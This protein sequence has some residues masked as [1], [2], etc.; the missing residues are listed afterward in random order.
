[1]NA[2]LYI[3]SRNL[4]YSP[5]RSSPSPIS[6]CLS[7]Y[8]S[9][10]GSGGLFGPP[11]ISD[12]C[13][14]I[15]WGISTALR[16]AVPILSLISSRSASHLYSSFNVSLHAL[17]IGTIIVLYHTTKMNRQVMEQASSHGPAISLINVVYHTYRANSRHLETGIYTKI[18]FKVKKIA[19]GITLFRHGPA[20]IS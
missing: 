2:R 1:M 3:S 12:I 10:S 15:L 4:K 18:S 16:R 6:L 14:A 8:G 19:F 9:K 13:N 5:T 20:L 7:M 11:Y 17:T